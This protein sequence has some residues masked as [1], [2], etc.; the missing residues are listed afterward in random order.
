[1]F[2]PIGGMDMIAQAFERKVRD[3]IRLNTEIISL[4]NT[5]NGVTVECKD[6]QTGATRSV[7]GDF[8]LCTIPLSVLAQMDTDFSA[9]FKEAMKVAYTPTGKIG[10]QMSRRFWEEDDFIYGGHI[11]TDDPG[12]GNISLPSSGADWQGRKGTL[13]GYYNFGGN[14]AR[15]SAMSPK[16]RLEYAVAYGEKIFPGAYRASA[17]KA[18][19]VAWHRVQYSIGGWANWSDDGRKTG[20][21]M[22]LKG[23][24][25]TLLA[26]EHLSYINGWMAGAIESAW[27]QIEQIHARL[28][29]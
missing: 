3:L 7:Q 20:Y 21:P 11:S 1:M 24:G 16:E 15:I 13:L 2:Q 26:G 25:R 19:S 18:F 10:I 27:H 9:P 23:E 14:A 12:I 29:G 17:E 5:D 22:L 28:G 8:C 4:R 6:T